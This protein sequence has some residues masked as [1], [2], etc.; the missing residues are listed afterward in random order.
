MNDKFFS[1]KK[2]KQDKIIN[3]AVH[4]FS[5]NGYKRGSTDIIVKEAGI[6]KGLL[7]HYFGSKKNLYLFIYEYCARYMAMELSQ[8][9]EEK[10]DLFE[11][12]QQI[13]AA[14]VR[15]LFHYPY[16]DHFLSRAS[17]EP[18]PQ[19][20]EACKETKKIITDCYEKLYAKADVTGIREGVSLE[21]LMNITRWS[22]KGYKEEMY[23]NA[24]TNPEEV[25]QGFRE[26]L[27]M[28]RDHFYSVDFPEK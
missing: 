23:R 18:D 8:S 12:F 7:F 15:A 1:L 10:L 20:G 16:M 28:L 24:Q 17:E 22:L 25:L 14:K 2:E 11:L 3:A 9:I 6:S 21:K 13:E 19:V 5:E 26:Y 27:D 4:V